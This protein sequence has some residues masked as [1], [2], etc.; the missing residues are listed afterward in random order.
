MKRLLALLCMAVLL[1]TVLVPA[2]AEVKAI[3]YPIDTDVTLTMWIPMNSTAATF[4]QTYAENESFLYAQEATGIKID[5]IHPSSTGIQEEFNLMIVS[6]MLPDI[7]VNHRYGAREA[8]GA[9]A[10]VEDGLFLDLTPYMEE[11]SPV[12]YSYIMGNLDFYRDATMDDGRIIYYTNFKDVDTDIEGSWDRMQLRKEWLDALGMETLWVIE[13][14]ETYFQY[15]LDNQ[16]GVIPFALTKNGLERNLMTA[17]GLFNTWCQKDGAVHYGPAEPAMKEY[18]SLLNSWYQKGFISND[19]T[20]ASS[21]ASLFR[22]GKAGMYSGTSVDAWV[23]AKELNMPIQNAPYMRK[24]LG[25]DIQYYYVLRPA[26][27]QY[28]NISA[29]SKYFKEAMMFMDYGYTL[30]GSYIYCYG[31]PGVAWNYGEDGLPKYTDYILKNEKYNVSEL[32]YVLRLHEGFPHMRDSDRFSI[33]SNIADPSTVTYRLQWQ[34]D[35]NY[36]TDWY[37][38]TIQMASEAASRRGEIMTEIETY[39]DEMV[40]KFIVGAEPLDNFDKYIENVYAMGMQEAIDLTQAA[41]ENF[42]SKTIPE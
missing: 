42:L 2:L 32:D 33:P 26:N 4:I 3:E 25:Q 22:A 36:H 13:D 37:L 14:Y 28:A 30:E 19:F 16:E 35:P 29:D 5:F 18:L 38:P 20:T 10:A 23:Y 12:Y 21:T 7:I 41:Y 34:D 1:G 8:I 40:L 6:G 9:A 11:Y 39:R 24:E 31:V 17:F 15:I 27:G